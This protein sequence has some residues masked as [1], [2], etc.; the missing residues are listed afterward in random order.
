MQGFVKPVVL[1]L[2]LFT[3][4]SALANEYVSFDCGGSK[5]STQCSPFNPSNTFVQQQAVSV[6][7]KD[8]LQTGDTIEEDLQTPTSPYCDY[9][10]IVWTV[11][12][13]PVVGYSNLTYVSM[14]CDSRNN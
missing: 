11:N 5:G 13:A 12:S 3:A 14:G 9:R 6:A 10:W 1:S 2:A 8:N 7:I 4:T